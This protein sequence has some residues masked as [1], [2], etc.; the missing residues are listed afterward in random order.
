[1]TA[2]IDRLLR[3]LGT[4]PAPEPL[5]RRTINRPPDSA[6]ALIYRG[7]ASLPGC[8]E[9]MGAVLRDAGIPFRYVGPHEEIR[10]SSDA[11]S[12]ASLYVQPGGGEVDDA[13]PLLKPHAK[14]IRKFVRGGGK[15][16]GVCLGGYLASDDPG[17]GFLPEGADQYI[18]TPGATIRKS[19][20]ALVTVQ[21]RGRPR[22]LYFQ[23][24]PHFKPEPNTSPVVLGSYPNGAVAAA[25][26]R[27]GKGKVAVVGPH[28]EATDDWFQDAGLRPPRPAGLDL[29]GDL[30]AELLATED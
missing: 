28:P 20:D 24:G 23:D 5:P 3:R 25:V 19:S 30:L 21:W 22:Q 8:P 2:I 1:M 18:A 26:C 7:P 4:G 13:W 16:F 10:L 17:F 29:A 6:P 15:Y 9:A 11:L 12:K 27:Y 14:A